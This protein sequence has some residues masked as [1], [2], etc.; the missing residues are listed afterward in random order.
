MHI[1]AK[2]L[3]ILHFKNDDLLHNKSFEMKQ[4]KNILFVLIV[5]FLF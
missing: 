2:A 5:A 4:Q 1:K 3:N